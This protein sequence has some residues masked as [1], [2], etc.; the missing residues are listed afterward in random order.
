M[1]LQ[2]GQSVLADWLIGN[3]RPGFVARQSDLP[4]HSPRVRRNG[5]PQYS[6]AMAAKGA[7]SF[8]RY[9]WVDRRGRTR[10]SSHIGPCPNLRTRFGNGNGALYIPEPPFRLLTQS[11]NPGLRACIMSWHLKDPHSCTTR[12]C[13]GM[14]RSKPRPNLIDSPVFTLIPCG[15]SPAFRARSPGRS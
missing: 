12:Q 11:L 1:L 10:D 3:E 2:T 15:G 6:A 7:D 8:L 5:E 9:T 14:A 4:Q 13:R